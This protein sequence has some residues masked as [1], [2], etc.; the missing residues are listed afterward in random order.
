MET[1][2]AKIIIQSYLKDFPTHSPGPA[3]QLW[4]RLQVGSFHRA[5]LG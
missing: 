2:I 5:A 3:T 4:R 1:V